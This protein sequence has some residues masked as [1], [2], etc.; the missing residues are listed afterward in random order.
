ML[1]ALNEIKTGKALGPSEGSLE[2]TDDSEG[3]GIQVMAEI[4]QKTQMDLE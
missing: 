4:Y 1:Q 3:V 2:M